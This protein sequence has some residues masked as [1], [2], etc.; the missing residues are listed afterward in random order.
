MVFKENIIGVHLPVKMDFKV[1]EAPPSVRGNTAQGGSKL[2]TLEGGAT[3]TVPLF[4]NT[5]DIVK[6]NT[7]TGEY[8]ERVEKA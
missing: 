8:V 5:N 4:I 7:E 2:V 3:L 1:T 6:V